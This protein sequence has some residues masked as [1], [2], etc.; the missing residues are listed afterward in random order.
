MIGLLTIVTIGFLLGM[1]H[2]TDPDH[3][4]AITTIVSREHSVRRSALIGA[5]WGLG[6]T[7]TIL[8]VGSAMILSR[9]ALPPRLGLAMEMAVA[10][11][12]I[13]LGFRNLGGLFSW[14]AH[15]PAVS[16][17]PRVEYHAHGD[18]VHAHL[19]AHEHA[20]QHN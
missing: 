13:F 8:V 4:I 10:V 2:A 15:R 18:Y 1:R 20:H 17:N 5:A 9:V 19:H 16:A 7:L 14:S 12:L 6:H 11:M 3:V